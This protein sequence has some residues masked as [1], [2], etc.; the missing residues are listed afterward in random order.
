M[1]LFARRFKRSNSVRLSTID[2]IIIIFYF[3]LV[4]AIGFIFTTARVFHLRAAT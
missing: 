4:L 2:T 3:S 1:T